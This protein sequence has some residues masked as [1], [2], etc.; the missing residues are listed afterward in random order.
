MDRAEV[1]RRRGASIATPSSLSSEATHDIAAA[2]TAALADVYAVYLKTKNFHWHVSG[3]NFR[4]YHLMFDQH[5]A[6][7][8]AITDPIA[9]RVRKVGGGTIRSIGDI[10][11][12]QR[13]LDNDAAFVTS[14][15]MIAELRDD[16]K[17]LTT[18][19]REARATCEEYTDFA[20]VSLLESCIEES[21]QRTW[22]LFEITRDVE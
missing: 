6:E 20:S 14:K 2:L 10:S 13:I 5:A 9:E 8:L 12:R 15:D 16:N 18:V 17:H 19:L 22:F 11:R 4:D 7:L 1:E 3:A 21:E